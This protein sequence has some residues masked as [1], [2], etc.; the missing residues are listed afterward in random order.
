MDRFEAC[1]FSSK[2]SVRHKRGSPTTWETGLCATPATDQRKIPRWGKVPRRRIHHA[3]K[4]QHAW[5]LERKPRRSRSLLVQPIIRGIWID[6][7]VVHPVDPPRRSLQDWFL[8]RM[9]RWRRIDPTACIVVR[10]GRAEA[11]ARP[12]FV[13]DSRTSWGRTCR[14]PLSTRCSCRTR[15]G[16]GRRPQRSIPGSDSPSKLHIRTRRGSGQAPNRHV[17]PHVI[18]GG[19]PRMSLGDRGSGRA[20]AIIRS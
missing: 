13:A 12:R 9:Q 4:D 7:P 5:S 20:T 11:V 17:D 10:I 14:Q 8:S 2:T 19:P 15:C 6:R 18:L 1:R 3:R 16:P